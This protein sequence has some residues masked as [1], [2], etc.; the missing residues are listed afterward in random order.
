MLTNVRRCYV[1]GIRS[2]ID[3][4]GLVIYPGSMGWHKPYNQRVLVID[5][6][7]SEVDLGLWGYYEHLWKAHILGWVFMKFSKKGN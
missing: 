3:D 7:S 6:T 1:D 4:F 5:K 2:L